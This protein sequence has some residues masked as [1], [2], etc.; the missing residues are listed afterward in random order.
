MTAVQVLN[1]KGAAR[2][3]GCSETWIHKLVAKGLLKAYAYDEEGALREH[4]SDQK[5]QGQGL[6][7]LAEDLETYQPAVQRRPRGSRNKQS[8]PS[9]H[10]AKTA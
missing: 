1:T 7:F 3:L 6:Y 5:R 8:P 10:D 9:A 2:K 4:H